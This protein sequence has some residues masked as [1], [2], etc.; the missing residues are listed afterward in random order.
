MLPLSWVSA[1]VSAVLLIILSAIALLLLVT[2][3]RIK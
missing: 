2:D 1:D 3:W